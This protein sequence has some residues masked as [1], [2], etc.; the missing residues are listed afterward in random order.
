MNIIAD[1]SYETLLQAEAALDTAAYF[2]VDPD[3]H[4]CTYFNNNAGK[5]IVGHAHGSTPSLPKLLHRLAVRVCPGSPTDFAELLT[6]TLRDGLCQKFLHD[7]QDAEVEPGWLWT[8]M[9]IGGPENRHIHV[10]LQRTLRHVN[11]GLT[12]SAIVEDR[13][14]A[15]LLCDRAHATL[16]VI[17][18]DEA[19][20]RLIPMQAGTAFGIADWAASGLGLF[21]SLSLRAAMLISQQL[22]IEKSAVRAH[23][24]IGGLRL[25]FSPAIISTWDSPSGMLNVLRISPPTG[26]AECDPDWIMMQFDKSGEIRF[27]SEDCALL[28]GQTVQAL[29]GRSLLSLAYPGTGRRCRA[30]LLP[31]LRGDV[32]SRRYELPYLHPQRGLRWFEFHAYQDV[33][34]AQLFSVALKDV[35][36]RFNAERLDKICSAALDSSASGVVICD[37]SRRG[38][39]IVYVNRGFSI[40]T[41]YDLSELLG[42][43]CNVLQG[44]QR[45]EVAAAAMR[46]AIQ[47]ARPISLTLLNFRKDQTPFWNHL[48][49]TPIHEPLT[50][51]VTHYLGLQHDVTAQHE[52]EEMNRR[53]EQEIEYVFRTCPFGVVTVNPAGQIRIISAAFEQMTGVK[54]SQ[55]VGQPVQVLEQIFHTLTDG[56]C[57]ELPA[58]GE[59]K[60]FSVAAVAPKLIEIRAALPGPATGKRVYFFR[61][62]THEMELSKAKTQFLASAAHELRTPLGSISGY[63]ELL[64]M[65]EYPREQALDLLEVVRGQAEYMGNLLSD[66]LDLSKLEARGAH[67]LELDIIDLREAIERAVLMARAPNDKRLL[68]CVWPALPVQVR[69][70]PKEFQQ[71]LANLLSNALKYTPDS[72][73]IRIIILDRLPAKPDWIGIAINDTGAGISPENQRKLFQRFFRVDPNG[74]IPGTGLGLA[75]TQEIV[76]QMGGHIEVSSQLGKGSTFTVWLPDNLKE[77]VA[78][79]PI[80]SGPT[81]TAVKESLNRCSSKVNYPI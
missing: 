31:L 64:L 35:T 27:A 6:S 34:V 66:L 16:T 28:A 43:S 11:D 5:H 19:F 13:G 71:V 79:S 33:D 63:T 68:P 40:T 69:V 80:P 59:Q 70:A 25:V 12:P 53:R 62:V 26:A 42:C 15:V 37:Y 77:N 50:G 39:P 24:Q 4:R 73:E 81:S 56:E 8:S 47:H 67:A 21:D 7:P 14:M 44:P 54:S 30:L 48:E 32:S 29:L 46:D 75:I 57:H 55:L 45:D 1:T 51:M 61:D 74:D 2:V 58:A 78:T 65:R 41:G 10:R 17:N 76:E 22:M 23:E 72:G 60:C 49:L 20:S 38:C 18:S 52:L 3:S 9:V 36:E